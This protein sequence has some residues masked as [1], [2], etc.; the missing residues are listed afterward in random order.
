MKRHQKIGE[1]L[2]Y[3]TLRY[4]PYIPRSSIARRRSILRRSKWSNQQIDAMSKQKKAIHL[5]SFHINVDFV[6]SF[7]RI[8]LLVF[9][10]LVCFYFQFSSRTR[11]SFFVIF[12]LFHP[13]PLSLMRFIL[14]LSKNSVSQTLCLF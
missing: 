2:Q 8:I 3:D 4:Q 6:Y 12:L 5:Y 1:T 7:S 13:F 9:W 10:T 11:A 14:L